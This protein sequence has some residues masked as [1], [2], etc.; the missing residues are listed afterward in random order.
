LWNIPCNLNHQASQISGSIFHSLNRK[1]SISVTNDRNSLSSCPVCMTNISVSQHFQVFENIFGSTGGPC[2]ASSSSP[3][4]SGMHF[5]ITLLDSAVATLKG[6]WFIINHHDDNNT[7][8][9]SSFLGLRY[10]DMVD[11]F[12]K[13]GIMSK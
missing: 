5:H 4:E 11:L 7:N 3:K 6:H 1:D 2:P 12:V 13:A 10:A 8:T 9:L